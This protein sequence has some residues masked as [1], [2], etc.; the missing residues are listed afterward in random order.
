MASL[1]TGGLGFVGAHVVKALLDD[2]DNPV[3]YDVMKMEGSPASKILSE[4]EKK[5]LKVIFGTVTDRD[6]LFGV[7]RDNKIEMIAH[8]G[9]LIR[10]HCEENPLEGIEINCKGTTN[11]LEAGRQLGI[12]RIAWPSS[13]SVFGY[14]EYYKETPIGDDA[15][16]NPKWFYGI[17]KSFNESTAH[18]YSKKFGVHS[19]G[20]RL[21]RTFGWGKWTG[22]GQEFDSVVEAVALNRPVEFPN[23]DTV[24]SY[25]Y[26]KDIATAFVK[27]L[28]KKGINGTRV[29]NT[30]GYNN[31]SGWEMTEILKQI[32]PEAEITPV[33]GIGELT[34]PLMKVQAVEEELGWRPRYELKEA[35]FEYINIFREQAGLGPLA[36]TF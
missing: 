12:K 16:H 19:I 17:C 32:N 4:E 29:Y 33:P 2:G 21:G 8:I 34:V 20:L 36:K 13:I 23:A 22:G 31:T 27:A 35:L 26:V 18:F 25:V 10:P 24:T 6:H 3:V 7:I 1:V 11:V 9:Y 14:P 15:R 5:R 30:H 28:K